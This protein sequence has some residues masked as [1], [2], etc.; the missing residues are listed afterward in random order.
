MSKDPFSSAFGLHPPLG[1]GGG[2]AG[3]LTAKCLTVLTSLL[4][5][6]SFFVADAEIMSSLDFYFFF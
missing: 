1:G 6:L 4:L 3:F 5:T 2:I